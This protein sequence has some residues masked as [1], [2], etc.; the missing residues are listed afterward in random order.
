M[1]LICHHLMIR[2][3]LHRLLLQSFLFEGI[4]SQSRGKATA[5]ELQSQPPFFVPE[6]GCSPRK[7]R[8]L[9]FETKMLTN[10]LDF[11]VPF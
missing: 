3:R 10:L 1:H 4:V 11:G 9:S 2:F 7:F 8:H 5:A 6:T